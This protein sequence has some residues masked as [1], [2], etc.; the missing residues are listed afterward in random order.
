MKIDKYHIVL[1]LIFGL[2]IVLFLLIRK[3][4]TQKVTFD[5]MGNRNITDQELKKAF[6]R[7]SAKYGQEYAKKLEQLYRKETAHFKSGQFLKTLSPGMEIAGGVGS[8]QTTFPFG[9]SSLQE[10][11]N[12]TL[13]NKTAFYTHKMNENQTGYAKTFIGFPD[14]H[15]SVDFTAWFIKNKRGGQ[16]GK[17]YSLDPILANQYEVNMGKIITH[18]V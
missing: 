10:Y 15:T 3:Q 8:T 6:S 9:W 11:A 2:G 17:W 7:I 1:F 16:F 5:N 12:Q 18:Y 14:I 4:L 13:V